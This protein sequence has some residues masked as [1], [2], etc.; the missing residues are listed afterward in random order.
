VI[1]WIIDIGGYLNRLDALIGVKNLRFVINYGF[2]M[3]HEGELDFR[4]YNGNYAY[5]TGKALATW[6][7]TQRSAVQT[8][9]AAPLPK[10]QPSAG[11][12]RMTSALSL[13]RQLRK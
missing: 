5:T 6:R 7:F 10:Y 8:S 13:L 12:K 11:V 1:D 4:G 2:T 3:N 9:M